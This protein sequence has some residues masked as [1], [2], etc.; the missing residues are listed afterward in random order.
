VTFL[1]ARLKPIGSGDIEKRIQKAIRD[2]DAD[3][4]AVREAAD[5]ELKALG[6]L[7]AQ[8]LQEARQAGPSLEVRQR[9]DRLLAGLKQPLSSEAA[10]LS[11]EKLR[12]VRAIRV[13]E[14]IGTREAVALLRHVASGSDAVRETRE[15]RA[16][17]GRLKEYGRIVD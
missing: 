3:K 15:A 12:S 4:F 1:A 14:Q 11:G 6:E 7:A 9:I 5:R 8:A 16:A 10:L 2:L 13:L 17:L